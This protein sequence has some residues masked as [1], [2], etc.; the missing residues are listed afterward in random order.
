[1]KKREVGSLYLLIGIVILTWVTV[2]FLG[3]IFLVFL[4][5]FFINK[6]LEKQGKPSVI[7][8]IQKGINRF[9]R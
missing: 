3:W 2:K 7:Y 9:Y 6:G 5:L 4:G 1:M 8:Y